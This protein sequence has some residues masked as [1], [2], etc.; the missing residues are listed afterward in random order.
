ML[1][2]SKRLLLLALVLLE[3]VELG[4][5]CFRALFHL[6]C[7]LSCRELMH[8]LK[9][10]RRCTIPFQYSTLNVGLSSGRC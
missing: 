2:V 10:I 5:Q 1:D 7:F 8:M 4:E 6:F 3:H 9:I